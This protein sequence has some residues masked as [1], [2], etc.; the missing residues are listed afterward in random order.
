MD[1]RG[2]ERTVL[3]RVGGRGGCRAGAKFILALSRFALLERGMLGLAPGLK[4]PT[5]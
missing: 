2:E 3:E 5:R 4:T 1:G